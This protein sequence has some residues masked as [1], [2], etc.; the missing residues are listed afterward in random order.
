MLSKAPT[1]MTDEYMRDVDAALNDAMA[2]FN[3]LCQRLSPVPGAAR[4]YNELC[5]LVIKI[6]DEVPELL[7]K[8]KRR[9]RI[10][11]RGEIPE[12]D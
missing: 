9:A 6:Q 1:P 10:V 2:H 12:E 7:R 4:E 8:A 3:I 5:Q 11:E